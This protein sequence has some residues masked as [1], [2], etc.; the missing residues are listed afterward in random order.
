MT[1]VEDKLYPVIH[2]KC[3]F[4]GQDFFSQEVFAQHCE[5]KWL[6][7]SH[8]LCNCGVCRTSVYAVYG[9][10]QVRKNVCP[11]LITTLKRVGSSTYALSL[12]AMGSISQ[13]GSMA[14]KSG[15]H[16]GLMALKYGS[17]YG[18]KT[19]ETGYNL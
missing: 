15:S 5:E 11:S 9:C 16:Y 18:S 10:N 1:T 17:H 2:F 8:H 12:V 19:I 6:D 14:L 4:C 7:Q 13:Y 3:E